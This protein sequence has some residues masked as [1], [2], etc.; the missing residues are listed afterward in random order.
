MNATDLKITTAP[1][2][3]P[4]CGAELVY[5]AETDAIECGGAIE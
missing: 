5:T 1:I 4:D 2:C 3:C